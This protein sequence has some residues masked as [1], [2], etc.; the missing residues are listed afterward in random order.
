MTFTVNSFN[1][2][3]LVFISIYHIYDFIN[4][5][6][7]H[8]H[9]VSETKLSLF[10]FNQQEIFRNLILSSYKIPVDVNCYF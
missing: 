3:V 6:H 5:Y 7:F 9:S 4:D 8:L 10:Y 1:E 2:I